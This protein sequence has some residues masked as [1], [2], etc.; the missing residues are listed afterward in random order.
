M[1]ITRSDL[2]TTLYGG[3][4]PRDALEAPR[5][6]RAELLS[7]A[8]RELVPEVDDQRGQPLRLASSSSRLKISS[9]FA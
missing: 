3:R 7:L 8:V 6:L 5:E 4:D 1:P 9:Y 2:A